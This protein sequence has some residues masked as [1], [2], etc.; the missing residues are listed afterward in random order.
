MPWYW[1]IAPNRDATLTPRIITRRGLGLDT[2]FRYLEPRHEGVVQ[3]D[4]LPDDRLNRRSREGWQ[5]LH[6]GRLFGSA[7][8]AD[9][10]ACRTTT[11]KDFPCRT[12]LHA[13]SA[14]ARRTRA[15]FRVGGQGRAWSTRA[16]DWVLQGRID[17]HHAG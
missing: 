17:R 2:E 3:F 5:F 16:S 11:V 13:A 6:D 10:V 7:R 14:A 15:A 9:V 8:I 12:Q 1:N 4:W